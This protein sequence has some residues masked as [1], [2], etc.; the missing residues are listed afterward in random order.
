MKKI[1]EKILLLIIFLETIFYINYLSD[2]IYNLQQDNEEL[3]KRVDKL[4]VECKLYEHDIDL[5]NQYH[6]G[7]KN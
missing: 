5:I 4:E 6:N 3:Q 7:E 2:K 1:I